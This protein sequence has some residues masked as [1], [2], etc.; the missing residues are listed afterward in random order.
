M[1]FD[2]FR[3]TLE[4]IISFLFWELGDCVMRWRCVSVRVLLMFPT[5]VGEWQV[6]CTNSSETKKEKGRERETMNYGTRFSR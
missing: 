1:G 4:K 2:C 5:K 3:F 6:Q